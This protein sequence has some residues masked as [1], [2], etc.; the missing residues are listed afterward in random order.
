VTLRSLTAELN[1][2][3]TDYLPVPDAPPEPSS[4]ASLETV[5]RLLSGSATPLTRQEL[6]ARWPDA[7]P[8]PRA[9]SLWRL[10]SR[11]CE[12]GLFIRSGEGTRNDAFRYA[13][14]PSPPLDIAG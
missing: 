3:D 11:G 13:L 7:D 1:P 4:P 2:D 12:Q 10:L 14:S 5:R 6:L 8:P 9:D